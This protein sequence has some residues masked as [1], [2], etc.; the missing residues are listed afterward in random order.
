MSRIS[1]S[2]Q[3]KIPKRIVSCGTFY[4]FVRCG[5]LLSVGTWND[6][7][8]WQEGL[9]QTVNLSKRASSVVRLLAAPKQLR[10]YASSNVG[11]P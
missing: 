5:K 8:G 11:L 4:G 6:S 7:I 1:E 10:L 9:E 2:S 3:L